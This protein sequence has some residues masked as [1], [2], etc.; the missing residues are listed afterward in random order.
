M[1]AIGCIVLEEAETMYYNVNLYLF[2]LAYGE[3][4][5]S[6]AGKELILIF[7]LAYGETLR[8][9][10]G[11]EL[12]LIFHLA[13]G[14]TMRSLAGKELILIFHLAYG[15]TMRYLVGKGNISRLFV[16]DADHGDGAAAL[17]LSAG[18]RGPADEAGSQDG[19]VPPGATAQQDADPVGPPGLQ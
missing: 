9:L 4:M 14:E 12:I 8:Y 11:K 3:T 6:L 5:R 16:P 10:V 2:L 7:H 13:Y 15:E 18:R 17:P 1:G 19:R